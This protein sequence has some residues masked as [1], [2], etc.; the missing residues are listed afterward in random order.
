MQKLRMFAILFTLGSAPAFAGDLKVEVSGVAGAKG[1]VGCAL[2]ASGSTF[3]MGATPL[4]V[5]EPANP[6]GV[7]CC[8][9][10][11]T[12]GAYAVAVS[13]DLNGNKKTDT[14]FVGIP[15]EA[16]GVSN[17][18]RPGLRA[19]RFDESRFSVPAEGATIAVRIAR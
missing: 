9:E 8:F 5:W 15:T 12:P 10:S 1:Q 3:P 4:Q 17:N 14:N 7:T 19:P 11:V 13:H 6:A 18:V 16:W 2:H